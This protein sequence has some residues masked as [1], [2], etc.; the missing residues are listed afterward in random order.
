M[1]DVKH[2]LVLKMDARV[3]PEHDER[4]GGGL[5]KEAARNGLPLELVGARKAG[6]AEAAGAGPLP[7]PFA[8]IIH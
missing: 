4:G 2:R 5:K 7:D 8:Q 6:R 1:K 3:K